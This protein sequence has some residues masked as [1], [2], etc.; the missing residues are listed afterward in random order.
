MFQLFSFELFFW[1]SI[2]R[3]K[4][5]ISMFNCRMT[6]CPHPPRLVELTKWENFPGY[7][8]NLHAEKTR[9]G[10]IWE[11]INCM[12]WFGCICARDSIA[13]KTLTRS[14]MVTKWIIVTSPGQYIGKIDGGS[15]AEAAGLQEGDRIVEV[16]LIFWSTCISIIW[17][18]DISTHFGSWQFHWKDWLTKTQLNLTTYSFIV[19]SEFLKFS[20]KLK[21]SFHC[22]GFKTSR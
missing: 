9:Q 18:T 16:A 10:E 3:S 1:K 7:G 13:Q 2:N 14:A 8:F 21:I 11:I 12:V 20:S 15:P 6:R 5:S 22:W 4:G 17:L 19:L